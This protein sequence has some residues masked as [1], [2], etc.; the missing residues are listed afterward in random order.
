[1]ESAIR[2]GDNAMHLRQYVSRIRPNISESNQWQSRPSSKFR[3]PY[4]FCLP[5]QSWAFD[6]SQD[7]NLDLSQDWNLDLSQVLNLDL[8]QVLKRCFGWMFDCFSG[9]LFFGYYVVYGYD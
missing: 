8:S 5:A 7:W 9:Q 6:L 4:P 3:P 1:M 2:L